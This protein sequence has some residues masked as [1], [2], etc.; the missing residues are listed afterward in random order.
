MIKHDET[1]STI[2]DISPPGY[3][4]FHEPRADQRAGVGVGYLF[5]DQFKMYSSSVI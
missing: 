5:S 4:F 2:A 3:S 1:Q